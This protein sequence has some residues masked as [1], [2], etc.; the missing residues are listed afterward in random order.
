M[1]K[2][3]FL[4]LTLASLVRSP[5]S[6]LQGEEAKR[7][8]TFF[9]FTTERCKKPL[10]YPG[11]KNTSNSLKVTGYNLWA[12]DAQSP[13]LWEKE[14]EVEEEAKRDRNGTRRRLGCLCATRGGAS[15][16]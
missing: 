15:H 5:A 6:P 4:L 1:F 16:A 8:L 11:S 14:G 7:D 9:N 12:G 10:K 13:G 2:N 3:N